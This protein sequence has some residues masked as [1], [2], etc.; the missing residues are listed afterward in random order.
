MTSYTE[1]EFGRFR[2]P[3]TMNQLCILVEVCMLSF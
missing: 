2:V 3:E 1:I